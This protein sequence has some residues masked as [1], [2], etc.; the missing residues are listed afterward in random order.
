MCRCIVR[1]PCGAPL[2]WATGVYVPTSGFAIAAH[3]D[4]ASYEA[5]T[6]IVISAE[7]RLVPESSPALLHQHSKLSYITH[8]VASCPCACK[9]NV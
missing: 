9:C 3:D 5:H 4:A 6:L 8:E 2:F 7:G 1:L